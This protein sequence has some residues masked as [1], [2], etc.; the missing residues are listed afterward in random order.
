MYKKILVATDGSELAQKAVRSGAELAKNLGSSL[1]IVTVT[2]KWPLVEAAAQ[3][4]LGIDDPAG[5]YERIAQA[6]G[7]QVLAA[8]GQIVSEIGLTCEKIHVKN[9]QPATGVIET[10]VEANADLIVVASHGR[11]GLS[12]I[13]LGSVANEILVRSSVPVMVYR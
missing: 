4:E 7:E 3:A 5:Q 12:R 11:R 1:T 9:T 2:E 6:Q 10:A 13:L 8:A